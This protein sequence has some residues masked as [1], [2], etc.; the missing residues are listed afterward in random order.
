[1]RY[2]GQSYEIMVPFNEDYV[3]EFHLLHQKTYGYSDKN[4]QAEIVNIR[5]R[6]RGKPEKPLFE[7]EPFAG[8]SIDPKAVTG[9][10]KVVFDSKQIETRLLLRD[11]LKNGNRISG[12]ANRC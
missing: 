11:K 6:G 7:T 12:P 1:M 5:L 9:V 8:E 3:E 2:V 4:K 10:A